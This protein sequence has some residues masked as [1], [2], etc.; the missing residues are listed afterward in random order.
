[1]AK[2]HGKSGAL[3]YPAGYIRTNTI[4]FTNSPAKIVDSASGL[5]TAGFV[6][7]QVV[8][9]TGSSQE[10]NNRTYTLGT[11]A[12]GD[13]VVSPAPV[14][15]SAGDTVQIAV[16]APGTVAGGFF[17]WEMDAKGEASDVTD[18]QDSGNKTFIPGVA[19]W[20]LKAERFMLSTDT[21]TN[22]LESW[23]NTIKFAR[24]YI[25][26]VASPSGGNP[27]YY[28]EGMV[29]LQNYKPVTNNG[30]VIKVSLD[31]QGIG[32]IPTLITKT[33]SW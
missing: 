15:K 29:L 3:Y 17:N 32:T 33:T 1:M 14:T 25:K 6:E 11:V 2:T 7:S 20:N 24:F 8:V 10:E 4:S 19:E 21:T 28:Y 31:F 23:L 9:V 30:S 22:T 16:V 27:S 26:Y 12:A 18:F 5:V 13:M